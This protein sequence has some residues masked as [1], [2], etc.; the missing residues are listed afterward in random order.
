MNVDDQGYSFTSK[1]EYDLLWKT[2]KG[3]SY[4]YRCPLSYT[5]SCEIEPL[6]EYASNT[7]RAKK[8]GGIM[9][10]WSE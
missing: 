1:C 6:S 4:L 9:K 7:L 5:Q 2:L 8:N 10:R 3:F